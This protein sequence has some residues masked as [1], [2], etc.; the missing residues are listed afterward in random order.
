MKLPGHVQGMRNRLVHDYLGIDF[1]LVWE[2]T[3]KDLAEFHS[4]IERLKQYT[5]PPGDSFPKYSI[6][7]PAYLKLSG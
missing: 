5:M 4:Q 3:Q 6:Q 2:V 7:N 1:E